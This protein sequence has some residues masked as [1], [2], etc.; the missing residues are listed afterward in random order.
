[1]ASQEKRIAIIGGGPGGLF[2]AHQLCRLSPGAHQLTIFEASPRLGGK[3]LSQRFSTDSVLFEGGVAELYHTLQ[4]PDALWDLVQELGLPTV[5]MHGPTV[6]IDD[7]FIYG[8]EDIKQYLGDKALREISKF[9]KRCTGQRSPQQFCTFN[10]PKLN[11]H[12]LNN[13]SFD[14]YIADIKDEKAKRYVRIFSHS[15]MATEPHLTTALYGV[16]NVLVDEP[17]YCQL[18]S[19]VGGI[20]RLPQTL[21]QTLRADVRLRCPVLAVEQQHDAEGTPRY[22]VTFQPG[23]Q[24]RSAETQEF[25]AVVVALPVNWLPLIEW[26]GARLHA[27]L[28]RHHRAYHNLAHYLRITLLFREKFWHPQIPHSYFVL[29]NLGGCSV[30]DEGSR[31]ES[32]PSGALSLLLAG[33]NALT[34]GNFS[35]ADLVEQALSALPWPVAQMRPLLIDSRVH[36]WIGTVNSLPAGRPIRGMRRRHLLSKSGFEGLVMVG[37]YLFDSTLNGV[38]ASSRVASKVLLSQLA[39]ESAS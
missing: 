14:D 33:A 8:D 21:A 30:Y 5:E 22:L 23:E 26:R 25:D 7:Q 28:M 16:D 13:I 18:Y 17:N 35:D 38:L 1:M 6:V 15:D 39:G 20:E 12:P 10:T 36:R 27:A 34:L 2:T 29:D 9:Y 4:G 3:I 37:D 11:R 24:R 32:G 19:I 31:H